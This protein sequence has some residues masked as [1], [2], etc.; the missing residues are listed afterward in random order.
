V[1][2][3]IFTGFRGSAM[4]QIA[5]CPPALSSVVTAMR[6]SAVTPVLWV[7][8]PGV[9][10]RERTVMVGRFETS[11]IQYSPAQIAAMCA[12]PCWIQRSWM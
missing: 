8:A 12:S 3:E 6:S 9:S 10:E 7:N 5:T 2:S 4:S 11:T 1:Y